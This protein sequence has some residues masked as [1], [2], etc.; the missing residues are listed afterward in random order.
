MLGSAG[1]VSAFLPSHDPDPVGDLI[2]CFC[3]PFL[4][5]RFQ[6]ED[7]RDEPMR[8]AC[9]STPRCRFREVLTGFGVTS[10]PR[11]G[12]SPTHGGGPISFGHALKP[13]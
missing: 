7:S 4:P 1:S 2:L 5:D 8:N 9:S 3:L 12:P 11:A 10:G 13:V 6:H